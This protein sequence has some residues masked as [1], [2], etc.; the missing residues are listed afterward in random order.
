MVQ[1]FNYKRHDLQNMKV[2]DLK[3]LVRKH[4][5]HNQIKRYSKMRKGELVDALMKHTKVSKAKSKTTKRPKVGKA[6][7]LLV[8]ELGQKLYG[9]DSVLIGAKKQFEAHYGKPK[10]KKKKQVPFIDMTGG[11]KRHRRPKKRFAV[12]G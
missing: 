1:A 7:K 5:L 2:T 3:I 6:T 9:K 8:P 11:R 10:T 4:N 12:E